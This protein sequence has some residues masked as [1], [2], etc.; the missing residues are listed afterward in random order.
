MSRGDFAVNDGE[1]MALTLAA[2]AKGKQMVQDKR[3]SIG[4]GGAFSCQP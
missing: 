4:D 1:K 3:P 2:L